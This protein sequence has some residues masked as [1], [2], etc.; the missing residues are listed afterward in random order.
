[1]ILWPE[2]YIVLEHLL[3]HHIRHDWYLACN[4]EAPKAD[5][6][7]I[8]D[9]VAGVGKHA[10]VSLEPPRPP[11]SLSSPA[12]RSTTPRSPRST[13]LRPHPAN[14]GSDDCPGQNMTCLVLESLLEFGHALCKSSWILSHLLW[15]EEVEERKQNQKQERSA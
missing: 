9:V 3:R 10:G 4:H 8:H 11:Q 1:M 15:K 6:P 7:P 13:P 14:T 5:S 2:R 12:P